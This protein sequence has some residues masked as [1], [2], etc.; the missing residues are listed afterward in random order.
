MVKVVG[1]LVEIKG[2]VMLVWKIKDDGGVIHPIKIKKELFVPEA[3][4]CLLTPQK[5]VH[6]AN[7]N[8]PKPDGNWCLTKARHCIV[9]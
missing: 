7:G 9:Y 6:Q 8:Y 2:K 4:S 5:W 3:P 1:G